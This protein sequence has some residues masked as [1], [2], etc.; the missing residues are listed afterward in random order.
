MDPVNGMLLAA[1][2]GERMEPL[3]TVIAKP[4]LEVLGRPL[5]TSA[6]AHL[7]RSGCERTVINLHRHPE[8]VAAAARDAGG[9][10]LFSWEP[11]LLGGAGGLAAA[12]SL[13]GAGP[14]L[15]GNA[16]VWG[17]LDLAPLLAAGQEHTG[18]LA[19]R[20][21]PDPARWSSVVLDDGG[22][23]QTILPRRAPHE[24]ERYLFT[25]FQ[26]IGAGVVA[27]LPASPA[28][29]SVVWE[30]L[31]SRGALRGV[32]V[33]GSWH[34]VGSPTAYREL[35]IQLLAR[36][37]WVHP[38]AL[39]DDSA[40]VLHSAVGAAC[41]V[42]AHTIVSES[43]LSAG[44]TVGGCELHR[45]VVVGPVSLTGEGTISEELILPQGRFPLR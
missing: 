32:V 9:D 11:D 8:M 37:L 18:V 10:L 7:R 34:E 44:A 33:Q 25:G 39:V 40:R 3:S 26:L 2:R 38:Q 30:A 42:R 20:R 17:D 45:C 41:T 19:L 29:M 24:G 15:V 35:I 28:G 14:V 23:V 12:R 4:A 36:G 5:L 22:Q 27:E 13:L 21:H 43:V 16:D 31:R 1:G 6:L